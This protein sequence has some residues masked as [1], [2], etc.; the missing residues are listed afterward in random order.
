MDSTVFFYIIIAAFAFLFLY[1]VPWLLWI[2]T[3][4]SGVNISL[5]EMVLMRIRKSPMSQIVKGLIES[6]K[7]NLGLK[8]EELEA[9]G[10]A[11]GNIENVVH[12]MI[13]A[14]QSGLKL[15]FQEACQ[16][17]LNG[18][19]L[20]QMV[21]E[22]PVNTQVT[23]L[24]TGETMEA[25]QL[26]TQRFIIR[27]IELT[28]KEALFAYRSD[29]I[30]NQYQ[31]WIPKTLSDVEA[32]I[33]KISTT[34]NVPDTWFQLA[35]I[36]KESEQ[37]IGDL[38]IHF[39]DEEQLEFGCTLSKDFQ[40]KGYAREAIQVLINYLFKELDKHR[41]IASIDPANKASIKLVEH[42]GFRKEAHFVESIC[43][44]GQWVDDVIYA[45]LKR[46][47]S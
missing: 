9:F 40:G 21:K 32:F 43:I 2:V 30:T 16:A 12:G 36:E 1:Y 46:E 24:A 33:S 26:E 3:L 6:H 42:L 22:K 10:L 18:V 31:G 37:L 35:I 11:D 47:W 41:I 14:K 27:A 28:D 20:L 17:D 13:K 8:R 38:G 39:I 19:D 4:V 7:A 25:P 45:L 5:T 23:L 34:F 44:N 29:A 15:S